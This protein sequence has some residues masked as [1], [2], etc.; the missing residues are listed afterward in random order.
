MA[1]ALPR[2]PIPRRTVAMRPVAISVFAVLFPEG[3]TTLVL[4]REI[5]AVVVR[6]AT[7][8]AAP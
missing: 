1:L 7:D 2:R 8:V 6:L 4:P 3:K 5:S